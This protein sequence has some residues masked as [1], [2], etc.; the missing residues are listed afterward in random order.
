M[1][2]NLYL[3]LAAVLFLSFLLA[4]P[5]YADCGKPHGDGASTP[6]SPPTT[7]EP[8]APSGPSDSHGSTSPSETGGSTQDQLG[9]TFDPP[10]QGGGGGKDL[11][12]EDKFRQGVWEKN[13]GLDHANEQ[14][15]KAKN[16]FSDALKDSKVAED[17]A[18]KAFLDYEKWER[19]YDRAKRDF[20]EAAQQDWI[21]K[22]WDAMEK[23]WELDKQEPGLDRARSEA[24]KGVLEAKE[25]VKK[26]QVNLREQGKQVDKATE[27]YR[28]MEANY[29]ARQNVPPPKPHD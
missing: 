16:H 23:M 9:T 25:E 27:R 1:K 22:R 19:D 3:F 24:H 13:S 15:D 12:D 21:N 4:A 5:V 14:L 10:E 11:V 7:S 2:S 6:S 20:K 28:E 8:S 29:E 17:K 26:S 18:D